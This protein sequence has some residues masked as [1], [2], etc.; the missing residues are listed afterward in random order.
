MSR[1]IIVECTVTISNRPED[2][3]V[4]VDL[5]GGLELGS[6]DRIVVGG[7]PLSAPFGEVLTERRTATLTRASWL[8][9]TLVRLTGDLGCLELLESSFS[10][11][12][13]L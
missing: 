11:T 13:A 2:V 1:A 10:D 9:R 6:G 7:G 12:R 5:D 4:H 3:S 8:R